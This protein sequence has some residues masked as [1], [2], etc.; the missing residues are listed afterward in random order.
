MSSLIRHDCYLSIEANAFFQKKSKEKTIFL[1]FKVPS[2]IPR[3]VRHPQRVGRRHLPLHGQVL[4]R[5]ARVLPRRPELVSNGLELGGSEG[6]AVAGRSL[7]RLH[8]RRLLA[9]HTER[10]KPNRATQDVDGGRE[11]L[12][13]CRRS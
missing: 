9:P 4:L 1:Y 8:R 5:E 12:K 2:C 7:Q 10:R 11:T 6:Q 13:G 3:N